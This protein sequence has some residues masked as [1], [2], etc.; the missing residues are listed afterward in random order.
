MCSQWKGEKPP[1][2]EDDVVRQAVEQ[3]E[4]SFQITPKTIKQGDSIMYTFIAKTA[5][6]Y[7]LEL[8]LAIS[9]AH[10]AS[11]RVISIAERKVR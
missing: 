3:L 5:S 7:P 10:P 6:E 11:S 4:T 9:I 8:Q 2:A 1:K